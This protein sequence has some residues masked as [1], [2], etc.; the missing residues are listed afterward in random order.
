[1]LMMCVDCDLEIHGAYV[2][3][4]SGES[5]SGARADAYA[6]PPHSTDCRPRTPRKRKL[7]KL[8]AG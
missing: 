3:V 7:R 4:S 2:L 8:L 5:M 1:M 6:H